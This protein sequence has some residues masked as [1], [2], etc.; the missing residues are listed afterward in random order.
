MIVSKRGHHLTCRQ[1]STIHHELVR[2]RQILEYRN[3]SSDSFP[4]NQII[5]FIR[6]K[7]LVYSMWPICSDSANHMTWNVIFF[8]WFPVKVI[9]STSN[10]G[11]VT[12]EAV[13]GSAC[14]LNKWRN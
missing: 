12:I 8:G 3:S 9:P 4:K 7:R 1:A 2:N 14:M 11:C 10:V 6:K 5:N 13:G